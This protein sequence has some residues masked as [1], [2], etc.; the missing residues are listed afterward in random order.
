[1]HFQNFLAERWFIIV[2]FGTRRIV[3][4][5]IYKVHAKRQLFRKFYENSREPSIWILP[6]KAFHRAFQFI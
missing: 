3:S 5:K 1:M 6:L 4:E 2:E